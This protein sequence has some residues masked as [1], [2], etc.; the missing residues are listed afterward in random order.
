MPYQMNAAHATP[1]LDGLLFSK[2]ITAARAIKFVH[3][4]WRAAMAK[5]LLVASRDLRYEHYVCLA[6]IF[7]LLVLYD[8]LTI[9]AAT[10]ISADLSSTVSPAGPGRGIHAGICV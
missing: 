10:P 1:Q 6:C 9:I 8:V 3:D 5:A 2:S 4:T 7:C